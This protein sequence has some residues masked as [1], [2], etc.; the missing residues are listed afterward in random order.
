MRRS[1]YVSILE[2]VLDHLEEAGLHLNPD[3]C[4]FMARAVAYLGDVTDAQGLHPDPDKVRAINDAPRPCSVSEL[5]SYLGLLEYFS[6]FLADLT[7]VLTPLYIQ[8]APLLCNT[9]WCWT[10]EKE[11]AL[12]CPSSC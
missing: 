12:K 5:K 6:K 10:T 7:T 3:K 11:E 8:Y 2:L 1:I 4:E 9:P